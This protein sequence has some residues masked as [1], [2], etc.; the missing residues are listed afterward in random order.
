[1]ALRNIQHNNTSV[2]MAIGYIYIYIYIYIY[3]SKK[4]P[5]RYNWLKYKF[6]RSQMKVYLGRKPI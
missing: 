3:N 6:R 5:M 2:R 4:N 1:M